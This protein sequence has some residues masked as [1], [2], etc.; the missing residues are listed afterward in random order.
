MKSDLREISIKTAAELFYLNGYNSTGIN[1]IIQKS[2]LA[3][4]TLH[5][6]FKS[7]EKLKQG[8]YVGRQT[9]ELVLQHII[10][11]SVILFC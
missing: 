11:S 6:H 9:A 4:A 3:I 7:K 2:K 1:E 8:I 5:I 10:I